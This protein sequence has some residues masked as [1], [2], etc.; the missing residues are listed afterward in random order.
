M[1]RVVS[2]RLQEPFYPRNIQLSVPGFVEKTYRQFP[3]KHCF[4]NPKLGKNS[5]L[6]Y[7]MGGGTPSP[8][9][10]PY[11]NRKYR[12]LREDDTEPREIHNHRQNYV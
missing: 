6:F 12:L 1:N 8:R 5:P 3:W 4:Q 9:N 7:Y 10:P 11:E 2:G